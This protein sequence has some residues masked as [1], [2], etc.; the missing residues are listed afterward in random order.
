MEYPSIASYRQVGRDA[1]NIAQAISAQG[2]QRPPQELGPHHP[3]LDSFHRCVLSIGE[4]RYKAFQAELYVLERSVR[5][6]IA[7]PCQ[8]KRLPFV[9]DCDH[10]SI[11]S[12]VQRETVTA[13]PRKNKSMPIKIP[14]TRNLVILNPWTA[15]L[16]RRRGPRTSV[17][18]PAQRCHPRAGTLAAKGATIL[19][20]PAAMKYIATINDAVSALVWHELTTC[21][22]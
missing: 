21:N 9:P 19:K 7:Q 5:T 11:L 1:R 2:V 8:L 16:L 18:K 12:Q 17:I 22:Q 13:S 15:Q 6:N 20:I 14:S 4:N 3:R 10:K